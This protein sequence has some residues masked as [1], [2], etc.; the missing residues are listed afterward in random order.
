MAKWR[1]DSGNLRALAGRHR[2]TYGDLAELL[3]LTKQTIVTRMNGQ[4]ELTNKE[5]EKL[6]DKF[7]I[8][9]ND[10]YNQIDG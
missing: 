10:F 5:I 4:S 3:N 1:Y 7:G 9:P 2:L 6:C 8:E